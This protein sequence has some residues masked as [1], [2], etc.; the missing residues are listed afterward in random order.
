VKMTWAT[1]VLMPD[2]IEADIQERE[3]APLRSLT[4]HYQF[5][6]PVTN[7]KISSGT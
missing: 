2:A 3:S 4:L 6:N 1:R 7:F 5:T